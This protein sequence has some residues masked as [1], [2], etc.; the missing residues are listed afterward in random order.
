LTL[1]RGRLPL[2]ATGSKVKTA[3]FLFLVTIFAGTAWGQASAQN[4]P[5]PAVGLFGRMGS[6]ELAADPD[7]GRAL[8]EEDLGPF[9]VGFLGDLPAVVIQVQP[10]S[11]ASANRWTF[12]VTG[13]ASITNQVIAAG[14]FLPQPARDISWLGLSVLFSHQ[15][16]GTV[17]QDLLGPVFTDSQTA[18]AAP[19]PYASRDD[20]EAAIAAGQTIPDQYLMACDRYAVNLGA[21]VGWVVPLPG[22]KLRL[23]AGWNPSVRHLRY[24]MSLYRPF[25]AVMRQD[26]YAWR[27][28]DRFVVGAYFDARDTFREPTRGFYLGQTVAVA[29]GPLLG[30]RDFIRTDT[31]LEGFLTLLRVPIGASASFRLVFAAHSQLS[32][33]LPNFSLSS[34]SF[35]TNVDRTEQFVIDGISFCR[36]C[37]DPRRGNALWDN[38]L[39]LRIPIGPV[40][41]IAF[42]DAAALWE[43]PFQAPF[44]DLLHGSFGLGARLSSPSFPIRAYIARGFAVRGGQIIWASGSVA[45][46]N[47]GFSLVLSA[48]GEPF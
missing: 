40:W 30:A 34:L 23:Q 37:S 12:G 8:D 45:V 13:A 28:V 25:E 4:T 18:I 14:F 26:V 44:G 47:V 20:W 36:G 33:L 24:D 3:V 41:M 42:A 48:R 17:L 35:Q 29:G 5:Q 21:N 32:V 27:V 7:L 19:D 1:P 16:D 11:N 31:R 9:R 6:L 10:Q 15:L 46:G 2:R 38:K 43:Q 39:E 22:G